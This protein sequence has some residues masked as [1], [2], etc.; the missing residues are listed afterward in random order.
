M[1]HRHSRKTLSWLSRVSGKEKWN[2][3]FLILAQTFLGLS[4]IVFAWLL[5]GG[6]DCA[7]AKDQEG[8]LRYAAAM[9]LVVA[10][11]IG[12]R[13]L[14]RFLDEFTR[15]GLENR[16]K[17]RLLAQLLVRDY[18]SVTARHS[19]EWMNRMTSDAVV[20]ANGIT[21]ILPNVIGMI[22][23]LGGALYALLLLMPEMGYLLVPGGIAMFLL[24]TVFRNKLKRLHAKIREADGKM[25]ILIT[26]R[27]TGMLIVRSFARE[28]QTMQE[29]AERMKHHR[30]A[31]M[32]QSNF[33][34]FCSTGLALVVN[35][36]YILGVLYCSYGILRGSVS[37]GSFTAVL[38]LIGQVQQPFAGLSGYL[39]RFYA[40]LASAERL[41]EA[42]DFAQL[43]VDKVLD[44]NQAK[45]FYHDR[46]QALGLR[47][48]SFTYLPPAGEKA[49]EKKGMPVVLKNMDITIH[50]GECV[51]IL[52]RSGSG[53]STMLKLLMSLYPLDAGERYLKMRD[54]TESVLDARYA[55]LFAYVPQG[56]QL[57]SGSI[58]EMVTFS[59]P[60]KLGDEQRIR[61]ALEIA[62]A[63]DFVDALP[64]GIDTKLGERGAGLSEGQLQRIAI[65]RAVY[66]EN[67]IL[68]LD[69]ATSALDE[70]TEQRLVQNLRQM[71]DRTVLLVT[72][73]PAMLKLCTRQVI[74]RDN[75]IEVTNHGN[76]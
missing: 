15:S 68:V 40:L 75:Q 57:M 1:K 31:R 22:V 3:F 21:D 60:Q 23:K 69:E 65:A 14:S 48:A 71:T 72:H 62:C 58:R 25:R 28:N 70:E 27:L 46:F 4:G 43:D 33:G 11:Q 66:S 34:N 5:R 73:R 44:P 12:V 10:L 32:K 37:Y 19:G 17:Q 59:D 47:N 54:G 30:R 56:N 39:P 24:S 55:R 18:A 49:W 45:D 51:A 9:V 7:A 76:G 6:I 50:K 74:L 61:Q 42:E 29:A 16:F 64:Q 36:V 38:Q 63:L 8:F 67:P 53:K 2:I 52:G 41:M 20:V 35:I 13:A 26:E